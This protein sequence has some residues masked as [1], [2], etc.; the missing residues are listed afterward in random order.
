MA[1]L[2]MENEL[3]CLSTRKRHLPSAIHDLPSG[4]TRRRRSRLSAITRLWPMGLALLLIAGTVGFFWLLAN[5]L[6]FE[7]RPLPAEVPMQA[8]K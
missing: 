1:E 3:I 4:V 5:E 2:K 8:K 7:R 6:R